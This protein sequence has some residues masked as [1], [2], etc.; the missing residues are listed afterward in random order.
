M[1]LNHFAVN[2]CDEVS[3][4]LERHLSDAALLEIS[5]EDIGEICV[6]LAV[7]QFPQ[8][9]LRRRSGRFFKEKA[10]ERPLRPAEIVE[11]EMDAPVKG[12]FELRLRKNKIVNE[13]CID[14]VLQHGDFRKFVIELP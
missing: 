6:L 1:V 2:S 3:S 7:S 12:R 14:L 13:E 8:D 5:A 9:V 11:R 4:L 10:D